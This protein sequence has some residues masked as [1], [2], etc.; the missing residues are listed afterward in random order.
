MDQVYLVLV[1]KG[2]IQ[3]LTNGGVFL[4]KWSLL[5]G[6]F[7]SNS[8]IVLDVDSNGTI[9]LTNRNA[10]K[11]DAIQLNSRHQCRL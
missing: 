5:G 1:N 11:V 9:F 4:N 2:R 8:N 3:E 10:G 6:E 7:G